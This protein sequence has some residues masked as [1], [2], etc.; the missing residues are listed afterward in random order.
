MAALR[1]YT[2]EA[3][4]L[5][6]GLQVGPLLGLGIPMP[7]ESRLPACRCE[8]MHLRKHLRACCRGQE[9][10]QVSPPKDEAPVWRPHRRR[11][12]SLSG[13][14]LDSFVITACAPVPNGRL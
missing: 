4:Q 1:L 8:S 9:A 3:M 12:R 10:V 2:G 11:A 7:A 13:C 14:L 6:A 5:R